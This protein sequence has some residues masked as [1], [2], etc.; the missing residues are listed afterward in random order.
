MVGAA[1]VRR[2]EREPCELLTVGRERLD[3]IDQA[4]VRSFMFEA[5]PDAVIVA[6]A[7]VGGIQANSALSSRVF[8]RKSRHPNEHHPFGVSRGC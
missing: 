3:L 4:A 2:L 6:A 7:K 1:L 5:R 8:V